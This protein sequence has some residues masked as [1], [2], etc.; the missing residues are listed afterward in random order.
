MIIL[1]KI[2]LKQLTRNSFIPTKDI[3]NCD[4]K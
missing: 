2:M 4:I 1:I 3:H